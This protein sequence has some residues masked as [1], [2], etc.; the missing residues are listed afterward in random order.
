DNRSNIVLIGMAGCGKS[1]VGR[2]LAGML[3]R[4]FVDTDDLIVLAQNRSLQDIM[5]TEGASGFRRIEEDVLL[6]INLQD[7][8]IATGGSSI[9]SAAGMT[10]L[11]QNG[12]IIL[13]ETGPDVLLQRVGDAAQRGLVKRPGQKFE[14]LLAERR[15]LYARYADLT[16]DCSNMDQE[17][18]CRKIISWLKNDYH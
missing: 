11:R 18:V 2:K 9:Y 5:D 1:T 7:H 15:P 17:G 8:V 14:D 3:D 16:V 12:L 13:L 6:S 10:H 4:P